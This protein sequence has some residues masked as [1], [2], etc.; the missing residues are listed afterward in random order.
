MGMSLRRY[1]FNFK[2]YAIRYINHLTLMENTEQNV[3]SPE[4]VKISD[5]EIKPAS[6]R[7]GPVG[8]GEY[9]TPY[10][11]TIC[12]SPGSVFET[13]IAV[14]SH[15]AQLVVVPNTDGDSVGNLAN[16]PEY[17]TPVVML[18]GDRYSRSD[19][20]NFLDRGFQ[21][22]K[23]FT[24]SDKYSTNGAYFDE[25][26]V[27]FGVETIYDHVKLSNSCS[28]VYLLE[29]I[30]CAIIPHY[31]TKTD[32]KVVNSLTGGHLLRALNFTNEPGV[33]LLQ[34][35]NSVNCFESIEKLIARGG[36]I[37][38]MKERA[39]NDKLNKSIIYSITDD[40]QESNVDEETLEKCPKTVHSAEDAQDT[41]CGNEN[42]LT[43]PTE[44]VT[45]EVVEEKVTTSR[46][47]PA[48]CSLTLCAIESNDVKTVIDLA[49][50]HPSV[51]KNSAN[52]VLAY[53]FDPQ[54]ID[55]ALY[56]GWRVVLIGVNKA[57]DALYILKQHCIAVDGSYGIA[58][59]WVSSV[60][61]GRLLPFIYP[62]GFCPAGR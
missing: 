38:E 46:D 2:L 3:E 61:A 30:L 34:L 32:K 10:Q 6:L 12:Y 60:D 28:S 37:L 41:Q 21:Q 29:Y 22:V 44:T 18:F 9:L 19:V 14:L 43:P 23:I 54:V 24:D 55:K 45:E 36:M 40:K 39:V 25:R 51:V 50:A 11:T 26:V 8:G 4:T 16:V 62:Q 49:P 52:F 56:P 27:C 20:L 42:C 31:E 5:D 35:S 1:I 15:R 13:T 53:Y 58:H 57:P 48:Q 59:G 7:Y 47:Q 33:H 17:L